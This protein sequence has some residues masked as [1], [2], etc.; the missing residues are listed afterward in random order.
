[1][2]RSSTGIRLSSHLNVS[3]SFKKR[4]HDH[5]LFV[6]AWPEDALTAVATRFLGDVE[7]TDEERDGCI[8]LCKEFHTSTRLMS[9]QFLSRVQ[10]HNYVTPTSYLE[11]IR[12]Y[13]DLLD[14]KRTLVARKKMKAKKPIWFLKVQKVQFFRDL[15]ILLMKVLKKN[16]V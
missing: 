7:M 1:M 10:R 9:E 8:D 4:K 5:D 11:L 16:V 2:Y 12:T 15:G 6:Q 3:W 14:K 13:K